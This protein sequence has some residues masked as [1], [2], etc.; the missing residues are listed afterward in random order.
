MRGGKKVGRREG[1]RQRRRGENEQTYIKELTEAA[2]MKSM[3]PLESSS[4]SKCCGTIVSRSEEKNIT[5]NSHL[6]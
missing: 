5:Y 4:F 6:L 1:K 2:V 3:C